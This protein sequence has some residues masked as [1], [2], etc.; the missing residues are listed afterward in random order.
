MSAAILGLGVFVGGLV[1]LLAFWHARRNSAAVRVLRIGLIVGFIVLASSALH[2]TLSD[3]HRIA[4][5]I[6]LAE[7]DPAAAMA[8]MAND[9][10]AE[11]ADK[12][13]VQGYFLLGRAREAAGQPK[14]AVAAFARANAMTQEPNPDILAAEARARLGTA[15]PGS[16]SRVI[17]RTQAER[18]LDVAPDHMWAHYTLAALLIQEGDAAAAVPHL[19]AVLDA[20]VLDPQ[21]QDRLRAR[22]ASIDPS[23]LDNGDAGN[24]TTATDTPALEIEVQLGADVQTQGGVLFVFARQA[25][26]PPMPIAARRIAEPRFPL[27]VVLGDQHRLQPGQPLHSYDALEIGARWSS[28][29]EASGGAGDP[30]ART[31]IDPASKQQIRLTLTAPGDAPKG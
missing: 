15:P 23:A 17:A 21:T 10:E 9:L 25:E 4:D 7:S 8:G 14:A 30:V 24:E 22:L 31:R 3:N 6:A 12:P 29:G 28:T 16:E 1:S 13:D 11:L 27:T 26:G 20:N 2:Y 5:R 19:K 18:A